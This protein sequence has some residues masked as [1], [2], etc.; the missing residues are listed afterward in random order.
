M[1]F[2]DVGFGVSA[3]S[4]LL[5]TLEEIVRG[6]GGVPVEI[7]PEK[8]ALYHL[9][10]V[11]SSNFSVFLEI[12]ADIVLQKTGLE[13]D[14]ARLLVSRLMDS[15]RHNLNRTAAEDALSGPVVRKDW[16]TVH[17]H[18]DA[19][20]EALPEYESLYKEIAEAMARYC[21]GIQLP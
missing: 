9:A 11:I 15:T 21:H 16:S 1:S 4:E 6:L 17:R 10:A 3:D 2:K 18:M 12:I 5:E 14:V 19:L 7:S 13:T 20:N 8:R